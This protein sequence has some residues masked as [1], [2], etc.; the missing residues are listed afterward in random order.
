MRLCA[1]C[2]MWAHHNPIEAGEFFKTQLKPEE[3]GRLMMA[4]NL[5]KTP[6]RLVTKLMLK[7]MLR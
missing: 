1:G 6:G 4:K 7:A 3:M 5:G 2:H